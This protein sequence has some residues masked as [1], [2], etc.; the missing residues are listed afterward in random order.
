[1]AADDRAAALAHF[2]EAERLDPANAQYALFAAQ[3]LK[4][5]HRLDE[6]EAA[7]QRALA[8]DPT[9]PY[10]RA[11]LAMIALERQQ[12]DR[13]LQEITIARQGLPDD[14]GLRAQHAK[15]Y[16]HMNQPRQGLELLIGLADADRAQEAAT[17]EIATA[18]DMLGEPMRAAAAWELCL[19]ATT[20]APAR[21]AY[22]ALQAARLYLKARALADAGRCATIAQQADPRSREAQQIL[23]EI[24]AT[25]AR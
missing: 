10:A 23:D 1:M 17:F 9:E 2:Q 16:R 19:Q 3:L 6:A 14:V 21:R 18:F 12:F 7:I 20:G 8:L 11:T 13:A 22:A 24:R 25:A 4:Q 5:D 15:V